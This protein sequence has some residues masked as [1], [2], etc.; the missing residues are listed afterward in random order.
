MKLDIYKGFNKEFLLSIKEEPLLFLN[1]DKKLNVFEYDRKLRKLLLSKLYMMDDDSHYWMTYEEYSFI[2][3]EVE[4]SIENDNLIVTI[5]KNNI[6]PE[7]YPINMDINESTYDDLL[8][9]Y[10]GEVFEVENPKYVVFE[11]IYSGIYISSSNNIYISYYNFEN[12]LH[13]IKVKDY[14]ECDIPII[15][16]TEKGFV[17]FSNGDAKSYIES[18]EQLIIKKS[19]VIAFS[20]VNG[21]ISRLIE[22]SVKALCKLLDIKLIYYHEELII[23]KN[24]YDELRDIA[25]NDIKIPEFK[26]FREIAFYR[27]PDVNNEIVNISQAKIINDIID[28]AEN[29]YDDSEN[30]QYRDIFIT[31]FTG[32]G[33]SVMFQIPAVYLAKKYN[34]L[35]IIIE[36]V[37]A[38][39][40]DQKEKLYS[41]GFYK[42]ETFNSD[43]ITQI[44]KEKVLNRVKNG[45]VDLL[46]LSP[47]TLLSYSI[48]TIIG[49][50]EI[51]LMIVDEAHIVTSW[52]FGFRPDY[53][54]LGAFIN[55]MRN[56][57][58]TYKNVNK[59]IYHFPIC[60]FTATAVNG[61]IDDTIGETIISLYMNNPIKYIGKIKRDD[62]DFQINI[63][64][65]DKL[66]KSEY[67]ER[68]AKN[69]S[70]F[71]NR[72]FKNNE[73]SI[74][75][76]PYA[77]QVKHAYEQTEGF[78]SLNIDRKKIGMYTGRNVEEI[79]TDLFIKSKLEVFKKFK[80]GEIN[81]VL[82]T[83]A[84]GMGID[85]DDI[86]NVYHYALSGSISDFL[87]EIGRLARKYGMT[88][89]AYLD[90]Y[91]N[92]MIFMQQLFGM[93]QIKQWQVKKVLEEMYNIYKSKESRNFLI[94]PQAFTYIFQGRASDDTR[95][96]N[97]L[98][99]CLLMLEKDINS[100]NSFDVIITRPQ[101]VFTK[102]Y[103]V[104]DNDK[105][106]VVL[107]S[108][109]GKYF[110]FESKGRYK[111]PQ[112]LRNHV[113]LVSD[114]GDIY[115][116]DLKTL[117]ED[118]YQYLSFPQFKYWYFNSQSSSS[119]K[120]NIMPE[121]RKFIHPRQKINIQARH[122]LN[123]N[124][125]SQNILNDMDKISNDLYSK[126]SN[127][128]FSLE[129]FSNLIASYENMGKTKANL[130]ANSLFDLVDPGKKCV[131]C[132][133]DD[134]KGIDLYA[135]ANGLFS[136][137]IKRS[138]IKASIIQKMDTCNEKSL[139]SFICIETSKRD[140]IDSNTV[141]LKLLS[142]FDYI[143]YEI[144]GGE[145]P[146]IFVRFN[147]PIKLS[148]IVSGS[149]KYNNDYVSNAKKKHDRDIEIM[150]YFLLNLKTKEERWNYI[151]D[152]FLGKNVLEERK[153]LEKTIDLSA[154]VDNKSSV[155]IK[156]GKNWKDIGV[157]MEDDYLSILKELSKNKIPLPEYL[158]T[159]IRGFS[160]NED[161]VMSWPSK[162]IIIFSEDISNEILD[163]CSRQGIIAYR[164]F[165]INYKRLKEELF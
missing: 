84:F 56:R 131:R 46:Y 103:V 152:Y 91:A 150:K 62:I 98:K 66:P 123:I 102:A 113:T 10:E 141:A 16:S 77:S 50:R 109:Y 68:K 122:G 32:A 44:E 76:F 115:V 146:E 72:S 158:S 133:R 40:Q 28:Q 64:S 108:K 45:E 23:S 110:K 139:S 7:L 67:E 31:A 111:S 163:L 95:N 59:K 140:T 155:S 1:I 142:I 15:D 63:R 73:K 114:V 165:D 130:I 156:P 143:S 118:Y 87:Q 89:I 145:E 85:L 99:T 144:T 97:K 127:T 18:F 80:N 153:I 12:D 101:S 43:L 128:Y 71:L 100:K 4:S 70:E 126:F 20:K 159:V 162:N 157:F 81:A 75:Y 11:K 112:T 47:E 26:D 96:M 57:I 151:E 8:L 119:E 25:I 2:K 79:S 39:M 37:K 83:K 36:P 125:I 149:I 148:K 117:W 42:V 24:L 54:Y 48:D 90:Y 147:D 29:A 30:N 164:V 120:V 129:E 51:G 104:I 3:S 14:Y 52:G 9:M 38:L 34:K 132:R 74:V 124:E 106:D 94:S 121:I 55:R 116:I 60:A 21:Q 5:I 78:S 58:K 17:I 82:A 33:K 135:L 134:V 92:D 137:I 107:K 41:R 61:G 27:N 154:D 49:D 160:W 105:N 6:Y 93:S 13:K 69:L 138:I 19:K 136:E 22:K 53:W 86:N 65:I 35:T 88:G 161:I